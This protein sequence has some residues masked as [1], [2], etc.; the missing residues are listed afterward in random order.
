M[1]STFLYIYIHIL[2]MYTIQSSC[3]ALSYLLTARQVFSAVK[4]ATLIVIY[5]AQ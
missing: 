3:D 5:G 2:K 1:L 4:F